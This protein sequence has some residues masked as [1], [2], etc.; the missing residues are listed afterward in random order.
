LNDEL[1]TITANVVNEFALPHGI[2]MI[3]G[4]DVI[5]YT[6]LCVTGNDDDEMTVSFPNCRKCSSVASMSQLPNTLK[7]TDQD[8]DAEFSGNWVVKW[9]WK[10]PVNPPSAA[11]P[12]HNIVK[13]EDE[14]L[15][16]AELEEWLKE[17]I[18]IKHDPSVY[19]DVKRFL[20]I[21]AVRQRKGD[22]VKV[23]PV[24]DYRNLNAMIESH[25]GDATPACG[26]T[27]RSWRQ[28]PPNCSMLDL[29][30][31]YLQ[32]HIDPSLWPY[33]AVR[34]RGQDYL[35]TRLGF[36]LSSA[37]KIMTAIVNTVLQQ[38]PL[39]REGSSSYIDDVYISEDIISCSK[40]KGHLLKWGLTTKEAQ[41]VG[42]GEVRVL[43]LLIDESMRWRRDGPPPSVKDPYPTRR[44]VHKF[45]GECLGHF[46][47]AGWLRVACAY[48]Q[49][50]MASEGSGWD[51]P[52][53]NQAVKLINE[54][55]IKLKEHDPVR[56]SWAVDPNAPITVWT[57]ASSIAY[58]VVLEVEGNVIEDAS[59][60]RQEDSTHINRC[61]LDAAIKGLNLALKWGKRKI[62]IKTDSASVYKWLKSVLERNS[63][64]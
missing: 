10:H 43:G 53:S 24:L 37:P 5:R 33:Q 9:H 19:G 3:L 52:V 45:L 41:F 40:V 1:G 51:D 57:D 56:G 36:G 20:P 15:C 28:F 54:L 21:I 26:A 47:V 34:W 4:I 17:G 11:V 48:I 49:R 22:T 23:R 32:V 44:Q 55:Q 30:R 7:I 13:S 12:P 61:E 29:K 14:A 8:F 25:P 31:A 38:D 59:W 39:V 35:L 6:G 46:P 50:F 63:E 60:L 27:L 16:D 18:L 2:D 62:T 58:G 42:Q 64:C